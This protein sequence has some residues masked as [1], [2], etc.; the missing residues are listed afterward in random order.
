MLS[1]ANKPAT[2][3]QRIRAI[4]LGAILLLVALAALPFAR[5]PGPEVAAFMPAFAMAVLFS[6]LV[7]AYLFRSQF[8]QDR[9]PATMLLYVAYLY[10]GLTVIPHVLTFPDVV[11]RTG[12]LGAGP[13]TA[14]WLW[15]SWHG[16][17]PAILALYALTQRFYATRQLTG[18]QYHRWMWSAALTV[19]ASVTAISCLVTHWHALLPVIVDKGNYYLLV[20]SG[21]GLAVWGINA[22]ALATLWV[23]CRGRTVTQLW[24]LL[25]LLASLLDVTLTL[26]AASRY[27]IGWYVARFNS[28]L[29]ATFVL[30]TL[31]QEIDSLYAE[32]SRTNQHLSRIALLDSLTGLG[33]RRYFDAQAEKEWRR[34]ARERQTLSLIMLDIDHFKAFNDTY[35]HPAGDACLEAVGQTIQKCLRRAGDAAA[36]YGGEEFCVLLPATAMDGARFI[37]EEIR[38]EIE[39]LRIPHKSAQPFGVV[40]VSIGVRTLLPT[41]AHTLAELLAAADAALYTAK[42]TGRNRVIATSSEP[43]A[44]ASITV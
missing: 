30:G 24:L 25:V 34:A 39:A 20:T 16:G 10:S 40:T 18:L 44:V 42:Q 21:V 35:G 12:L 37:A 41:S 19:I 9:D 5:Q 8:R 17:F 29:A 3:A 27:S 7:T 2:T 11:T 38:H 36:R 23:T 33:N 13:Q 15:V 26:V 6:D 4:G 31:L 28:L 43:L 14:V 1:L 32:L 22:L